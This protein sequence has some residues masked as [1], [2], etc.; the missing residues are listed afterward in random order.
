LS[1]VGK[2]NEFL[3]TL[4]KSIKRAVVVHYLFD[5][6]FQDFKQFFNPQRYRDTKFLYD[7]AYG[8]KPRYF[9][10]DVDERLIYDEEEEVFEMYFILSG[11]IGIG[12][13]TI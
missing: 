12:Y 7:V 3:N 9:S 5:D 10:E 6:I 11:S 2:D 1:Q 8:L 4:P 13:T